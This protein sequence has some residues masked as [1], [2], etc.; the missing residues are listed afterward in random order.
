MGFEGQLSEGCLTKR[1]DSST[2]FVS[3]GVSFE[4]SETPLVLPFRKSNFL[5]NDDLRI[6]KLIHPMFQ[7]ENWIWLESRKG[8]LGIS[9]LTIRFSRQ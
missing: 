7:F 1:G 3:V 8:A 6:F 5:H 9:E 2:S 4:R